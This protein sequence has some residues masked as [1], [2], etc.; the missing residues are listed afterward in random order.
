M[1]IASRNDLEKVRKALV[2]WGYFMQQHDDRITAAKIDRR[3]ERIAE[4]SKS[5]EEEREKMVSFVE[6]TGLEEHQIEM[7]YDV[8]HN[9]KEIVEEGGEAGAR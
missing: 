2:G 1:D 4:S 3:L 5:F 8:G 9:I 7:F 6:K